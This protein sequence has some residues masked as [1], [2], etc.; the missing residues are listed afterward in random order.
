VAT[1]Y[2][3][4]DKPIVRKGLIEWRTDLMKEP[5]PDWDHVVL[6]SHAIWWLADRE[7]IT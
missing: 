1:G 2:E 7:E 4:D 6:L 5:N 3:V